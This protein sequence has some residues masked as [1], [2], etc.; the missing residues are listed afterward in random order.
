MDLFLRRYRQMTGVRCLWWWLFRLRAEAGTHFCQR[1]LRQIGFGQWNRYRF[2]HQSRADIGD[3]E[4]NVGHDG[5]GIDA[6]ALA[7]A[8]YGTDGGDRDAAGIWWRWHGFLY[9]W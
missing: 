3:I 9:L 5:L 2:F 4:I 8:Q 6:I 7:G 1:K